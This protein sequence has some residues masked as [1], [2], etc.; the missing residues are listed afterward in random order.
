MIY[1]DGILPTMRLVTGA[2]FILTT[3]LIWGGLFER[4]AWALYLEAARLPAI[5]ILG[6]A[7]WAKLL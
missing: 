7:W 4:K 5:F 3:L 6:Y 2:V 1:C